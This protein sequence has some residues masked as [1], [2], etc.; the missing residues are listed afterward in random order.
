M[1]ASTREI[2]DSEQIDSEIYNS[3]QI[4]SQNYDS[5]HPSSLNRS[6]QAA[7]NCK[8]I[9]QRGAALAPGG[10]AVSNQSGLNSP[11]AGPGPACAAFL[12]WLRTTPL[13]LLPLQPPSPPPPSPPPPPPSPPPST[14]VTP[15]LLPLLPFNGPTAPLR[16]SLALL[17][18]RLSGSGCGSDG[19][20]RDG[21]DGGCGGKLASIHC[22][23][24][25][26]TRPSPP[27]GWSARAGSG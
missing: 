18:G 24:R 15:L 23:S 19:G 22:H 14:R 1:I 27:G 26:R 2:Y 3:E 16:P 11:S 5:E 4:H 17:Q 10:R 7:E 20:G 12:A 21:D 13:L 6:P 25:S 8:I 9:L